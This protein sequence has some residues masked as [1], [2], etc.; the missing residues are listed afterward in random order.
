MNKHPQKN[1]RE[2]SVSST[3]AAVSAKYCDGCQ[4]ADASAVSAPVITKLI[5]VDVLVAADSL[6]VH[7][8]ECVTLHVTVNNRS[9]LTLLCPKLQVVCC[10]GIKVCEVPC[11]TELKP[12]QS[13]EYHVVLKVTGN[14][15]STCNVKVCVFFNV[16]GCCCN[17]WSEA[18]IFTVS[19]NIPGITI[20]K[21]VEPGC[22][23]TPG[24]VGKVT[25][26]VCNTGNIPLTSLCVTDEIPQGM[27]YCENSTRIAGGNAFDGNPEKGISLECLKA[28]ACLQITY[29][30]TADS[31]HCGA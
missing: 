2:Q 1:C 4:S 20:K 19:R 3:A 18:L 27:H 31:M 25:L 26:T 11:L 7:P 10:D 16:D 21:A 14:A 22:C 13:G 6:S 28:G 23:L 12:C 24:V 5:P 29:C 15:P 17:A 9:E 30:I 8:G